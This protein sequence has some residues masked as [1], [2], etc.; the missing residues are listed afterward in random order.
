MGHIYKMLRISQIGTRLHWCP[1]EEGAEVS[2]TP[3]G[4]SFPKV[5]GQ[6]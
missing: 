4:S 5:V 2:D 3:Q 6:N 1:Y